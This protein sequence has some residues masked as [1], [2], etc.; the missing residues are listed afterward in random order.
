MAIGWLVMGITGAVLTFAAERKRRGIAP[1]ITLPPRW[2]RRATIATM[3]VALAVVAVLACARF[4][5]TVRTDLADRTSDPLFAAAAARPGLLLTAGSQHQIQLLT[6]RPVLL[7]GGA[8]D[9]LLYV[10]EAAPETDRILRSI[11]GTDLETIRR[12]KIGHLEDDTGMERWE[13]RTLDEWQDIAVEFSVTDVLA[14]A[15]W[16]LQLPLVASNAD[17]SLYAIPRRR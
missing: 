1:T 16:A 15:G 10:P 2:M 5:K 9:A 12:G 14:G 13:A 7:D 11:Y 4:E 3:T 17:F 6:R 8:L